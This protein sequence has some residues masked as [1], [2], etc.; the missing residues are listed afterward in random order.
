MN[1]EPLNPEP[2]E[3]ACTMSRFL[4]I[5]FVVAAVLFSAMALL[6][7]RITAPVVADLRPAV[8]PEGNLISSLNERV[9]FAITPQPVRAMKLLLFK[10]TLQDYGE[11]QSI[12]VDLSMPNMIMGIN[13]VTMKKSSSG[14]Y[15]GQGIIPIC[16]TGK[17]LWQARIIIDN[18]VEGKFF[19]DVHY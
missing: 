17:K 11:P 1:S 16:P 10:V 13:Q 8:S 7:G 19:F 3:K 9:R 15:E 14:V 18:Q 4:L 6:S 2:Y 5:F 12:I